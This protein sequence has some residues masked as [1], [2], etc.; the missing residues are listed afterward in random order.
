[1]RLK[2]LMRSKVFIIDCVTL[3]HYKCH[4]IYV[5]SGRPYMNSLDWIKTKKQQ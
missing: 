5:K 4:K 1:M 2:I 3:L